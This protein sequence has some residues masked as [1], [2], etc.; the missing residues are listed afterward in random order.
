[1]RFLLADGNAALMCLAA[2]SEQCQERSACGA[3]LLL[4]DPDAEAPAVV[5][6][7]L[8]LSR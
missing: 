3:W 8:G 1:M 7:G 4:A 6:S 5:K 2:G